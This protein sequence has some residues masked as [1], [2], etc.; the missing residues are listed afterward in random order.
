MDLEGHLADSE[1]PPHVGFDLFVRQHPWVVGRVVQVDYPLLRSPTPTL[2]PHRDHHDERTRLRREYPADQ[3]VIVFG[4]LREVCGD[5]HGGGLGQ[6]TKPLVV[7]ADEPRHETSA[8]GAEEILRSDHVLASGGV[9]PD[10][11]IDAA[12]ILADVQH[13][14]IE[15]DP[16]GRQFL[17]SRLEQWF[18]PN[19]RQVQLGPGAGPAPRLVLTPG[20]P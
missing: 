9:V 10:Q 14:V 8:I 16:A 19:L 18:Q 6:D 1:R 7:H 17:G 11:G 12:P 3:D 2:R 20:S 13:L 4:P 5:V 15:A